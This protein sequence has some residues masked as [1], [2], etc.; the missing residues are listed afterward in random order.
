MINLTIDQVADVKLRLDKYL[1]KTLGGYSRTQIQSWIKS[2]FVL[3]NDVAVKVSYALELHDL[4]SVQVPEGDNNGPELV[5]QK[6]NL[7][8]LHED[9]SIAVINKPAGLVVH[10]GVGNRDGTLVN[11]LMYYFNS[12]SDINGRARPGI[13]HR[14]DA[15]TSGVMVV[16]KTNQAHVSLADQFQDRQVKKEY[17]ALT[18]GKWLEKEGVIDQAIKRKRQDP[19]VF[20]VQDQGKPATTRFQLVK[21]F[22]HLAQVKF[23]PKTGRTHQIRVHAAWLGHPVFGDEKYGGGIVKA[24]G[25]IPE[26]KRHYGQAMQEFNRHALHAEKLEF[27]HPVTGNSEIF[28]ATLPREFIN[29][30]ESIATLDDQNPAK[31]Y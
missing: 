11:G 9:E 7:E 22:R 15:G 28:Q 17:A 30:I 24:R 18:W 13:V 25:F 3:V 1:Y 8:I 2:G 29:L 6:M 4:I 19:T 5:A 27:R 21:Q 14:L 31:H 23:F 16:A 12:L 20:A 26:L 10:P